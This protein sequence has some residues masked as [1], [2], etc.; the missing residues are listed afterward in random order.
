MHISSIKFAFIITEIRFFLATKKGKQNWKKLLMRSISG[1]GA[2]WGENFVCCHLKSRRAKGST[3]LRRKDFEMEFNFFH[4]DWS[5]EQN[6]YRWQ[7]DFWFI[8]ATRRIK[9]A[10]KNKTVRRS[11]QICP[12]LMPRY[13]LRYRRSLGTTRERSIGDDF[14][15]S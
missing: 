1:E 13:R 7:S 14:C 6:F 10:R 5:W 12:T 3:L 8:E 11:S 4:M 15:Y 2:E 9:I